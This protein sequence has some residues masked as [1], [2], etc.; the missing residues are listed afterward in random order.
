MAPQIVEI[1]E[2]GELKR[3]M[4]ERTDDVQAISIFKGIYGVGEWIHK[5]STLEG[6]EFFQVHISPISGIKAVVEHS[7]T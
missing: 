2:T 7:M 3:I 6:I 1:I 4:Y 5:A